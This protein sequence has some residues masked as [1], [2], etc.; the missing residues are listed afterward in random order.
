MSVTR[1][2]TVLI[3]GI[4]GLIVPAI[5]LTLLWFGIAGDVIAGNLNLTY[6]LWPSYG[7]LVGGWRS[8]VPGVMITL[9]S[10]AIN[11]LIYILIALLLRTGIR[12]IRKRQHRQV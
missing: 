4:V 5:V 8:T 11:C 3:G 9:S 6:V 2:N 10:V 1:R 7:M 12:E